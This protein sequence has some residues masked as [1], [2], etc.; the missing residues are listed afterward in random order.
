M[1]KYRHQSGYSTTV[2]AF[3]DLFAVVV[4]SID[5][6]GVLCMVALN[7]WRPFLLCLSSPEQMSSSLNS[8]S[9]A[10]PAS[11]FGTGTREQAGH[12]LAPG[13][14][15]EAPRSVIGNPGPGAYLHVPGSLGHQV[16]RWRY[17]HGWARLILVSVLS[18]NNCC[19]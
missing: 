12:V 4:Q 7:H 5:Q 10:R 16:G 3:R 19:P 2:V 15:G 18:Y 9:I 8:S 6:R 14:R 17:I 11:T 1:E 13:F